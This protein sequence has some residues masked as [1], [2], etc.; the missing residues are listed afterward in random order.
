MVQ[1]PPDM[2][3]LLVHGC[4]GIATMPGKMVGLSQP[5]LVA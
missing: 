4:R 2:I 1:Q 3:Q 5:K